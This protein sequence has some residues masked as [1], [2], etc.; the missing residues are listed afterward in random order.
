V[1]SLIPI[2]DANPTRRTPVV[3]I[4]LIVANVLAFFFLEPSFGNGPEASAY[5]F[6]NA[7]LPC[8]AAEVVGDDNVDCPVGRVLIRGLGA[9]VVPDR[10]AL[11]LLTAV[12]LS[13]FLH[14]GFLHIAGNMLF[15]WV[16]GNN[17][18]DYL[19]P[20]KFLAFYLVGGIVAAFAHIFTHLS[21]FFPSVGAS[22]AVAAV[23]GAYIVLFP[24]A[25]VNV[26]VPIFFFFTFLQLSAIAVLGLWFVYQFIIGLQDASGGG[27][28]VAWMAHVG[29]FLFGVISIL[30]L[31]GRPHRPEWQPAWRPRY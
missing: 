29:G 28:A 22:G 10:D 5:F 25:R 4:G 9:V 27:N 1:V 8:Q 18:E 16:F 20:V 13:T 11:S 21:D 30:L 3:T 2:S 12:L 19:G 6:E 24:R 7:P 14:A 15:L 31:G 23:M 17:I 26:L